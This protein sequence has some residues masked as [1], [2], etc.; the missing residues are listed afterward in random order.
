M[1]N[2][3]GFENIVSIENEPDPV[4]LKLWK[5]NGFPNRPPFKGSG[6]ER[7]LKEACDSYTNLVNN[8][9]VITKKITQEQDSYQDSEN[10]FLKEVSN[11]NTTQTI[12]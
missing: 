6:G 2:L 7:R 5:K 12:D 3:E 10:Y 9:N 11:E 1:K 4:L 8:P